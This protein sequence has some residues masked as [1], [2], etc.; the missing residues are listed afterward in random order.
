MVFLK[1]MAEENEHRRRRRPLLFWILPA[2]LVLT[3]AITLWLWLR[4]KERVSQE[5]L[6]TQQIVVER[7]NV[8]EDLLSLRDEYEAL[9]AT[10]S[11]LQQD[12]EEKKLRIEELLLE[13][14]KHKNDR[15]IIAK[16]RKET[17]T[18]R[19]IMIG[20]VHT[21]DS[22]NTLNQTLVAEKKTVLRKL[23]EEKQKQTVLVKEKEELKT[24]IAKGSVLSCFNIGAE[25][26]GYRRGGKKE[27]ETSK[28]RKTDK[29]KVNFTL[30]ENKIARPG[31]KTV[32]LRVMTPDGKELAEAYSDNYK[33]VFNNSVGYYAGKQTVNYANKEISAVA[34]CDGQG[35]FVPGTYL[36][37]IVCDNVVVGSTSLELD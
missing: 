26:V 36:I 6:V 5:R 32:F 28:A 21:I 17:E 33:F 3:N 1:V 24:T 34:Y 30:G 35:E 25:G 18:L 27:I 7:D 23:D 29:I 14:E 20:Y 8:R 22:L 2:A 4:E 31:E 37:E 10:D 16:L 9:Q 19:Q 13:A 12:I 11:L 15:Y